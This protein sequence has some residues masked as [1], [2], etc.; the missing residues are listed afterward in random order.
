MKWCND[1]IIDI[2]GLIA[3]LHIET[4]KNEIGW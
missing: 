4:M 2:M 1:G 3:S